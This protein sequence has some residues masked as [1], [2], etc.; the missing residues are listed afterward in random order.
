MA[1]TLIFAVY[2]ND[3]DVIHLNFE[4][5]LYGLANFFL[6]GVCS[7]FQHNLVHFGQRGGSFQRRA[8]HE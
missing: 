6:G 1:E 5:Q 8:G 3:G 7:Y 2:I 4:Q